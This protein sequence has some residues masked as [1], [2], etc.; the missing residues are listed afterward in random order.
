MAGNRKHGFMRGNQGGFKPSKWLCDECGKLHAPY[1]TRNVTL[2]GRSLCDRAYFKD[3][4]VINA[5]T[6]TY[7]IRGLLDKSLIR[8]ACG[9][10]SS[11]YHP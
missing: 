11:K 6:R 3:P 8:T 10:A 4:T 9:I 7:L 2:D 5:E 1:Q